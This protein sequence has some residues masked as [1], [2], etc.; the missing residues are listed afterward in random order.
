MRA[1][2]SLMLRVDRGG[3]VGDTNSPRCKSRSNC[4]AGRYDDAPADSPQ[5][6]TKQSKTCHP[7]RMESLYPNIN[8]TRG[9]PAVWLAFVCSSIERRIKRGLKGQRGRAS[10]LAPW[11]TFESEKNEAA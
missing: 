7:R 1:R 4:E 3:D 2:K 6:N 5:S 10:C 11:A 8:Q 9:R